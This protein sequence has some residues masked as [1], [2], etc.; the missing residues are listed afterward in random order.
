[1]EPFGGNVFSQALNNMD[2]LEE[3]LRYR[4][5]NKQLLQQALTHSSVSGNKHRNYERLEFLGDRVLGMTMAHLLYDMF[6]ND[7]EGEL[8]QRHVKLVC[9]EMVA[10]VAKKLH[11]D[12]YITAKDKE[13]AERT[14]VLCDVG[15][16]V[17]GAIYMDS[18]IE[19]AISFVERNWR[20]MIDVDFGKQKDY[21]TRLQEKFHTLKKESPIYQVVEKKGSEH[22]P[23]FVVCVQ[24]ENLS[25]FGEGTNKKTAEQEAAKNLLN[26]MGEK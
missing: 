23:V 13:T 24:Y 10:K 9:A 25:A 18:N 14:N 4:F 19:E 21:K 20:D 12:E 26:L 15:E 11:L 22:E 6:P 8:S 5:R 7:R 16:A 3:I 2:E 1:M 17:I